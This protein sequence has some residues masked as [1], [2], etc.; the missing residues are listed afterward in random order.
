MEM[1]VNSLFDVVSLE[2]RLGQAVDLG[3]KLLSAEQRQ[4]LFLRA[5]KSAPSS[6]IGKNAEHFAYQLVRHYELDPDKVVFVEMR[7]QSDKQALLRWSFEWVGQ[8]AH[9]AR[10]HPVTKSSQQAYLTSVLTGSARPV[11]QAPEVPL[12]QA[13]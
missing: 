10:S 9:A 7:D 3:V 5:P 11:N 6:L 2:N 12:S 8:S 13:C 4:Y 1:T